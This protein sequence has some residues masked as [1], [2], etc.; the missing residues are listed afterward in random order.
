MGKN[1]KTK[2]DNN[3]PL[4]FEYGLSS[5]KDTQFVVIQ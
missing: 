1:I 3:N 5:F 2:D 4:E